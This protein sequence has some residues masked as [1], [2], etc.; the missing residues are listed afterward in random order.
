MFNKSCR[1]QSSVLVTFGLNILDSKR[2]HIVCCKSHII[3]LV[4]MKEQS[5]KRKEFLIKVTGLWGH[6]YA[7]N[8]AQDE[9]CLHRQHWQTQPGLKIMP[10]RPINWSKVEIILTIGVSVQTPKGWRVENWIL[11]ELVP[12]LVKMLD[13][14]LPCANFREQAGRSWAAPGCY[15]S[16]QDFSQR[17]IAQSDPLRE[18]TTGKFRNSDSK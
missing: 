12:E 6:T 5:N 4:I 14:H 11:E 17:E 10:K 16:K 2:E 15:C 3:Y 1:W 8:R 18:N 13:N 7:H 9:G